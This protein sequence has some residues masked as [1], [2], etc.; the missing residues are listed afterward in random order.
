[1]IGCSG[2]ERDGIAELD[3]TIGLIYEARET[4]RWR[5]RQLLARTD[6]HRQA[7]PGSGLSL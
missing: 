7:E 2:I 4:A 1:L 3:E 5:L 6:T